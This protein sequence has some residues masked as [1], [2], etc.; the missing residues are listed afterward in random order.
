MD[1]EKRFVRCDSQ[2]A[3]TS[4][5]KGAGIDVDAVGMKFPIHDWVMSVHDNLSESL[6]Y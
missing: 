6:C 1:A 4:G 2:A 5:D 3:Q